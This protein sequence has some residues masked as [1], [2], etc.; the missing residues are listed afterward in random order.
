MY[1]ETPYQF[2]GPKLGRCYDIKKFNI[3][4][5][6]KHSTSSTFWASWNQSNPYGIVHAITYAARLV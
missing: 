3:A 2:Y 1:K 5:P 6:G 4:N